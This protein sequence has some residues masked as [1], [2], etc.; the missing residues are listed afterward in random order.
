VAEVVCKQMGLDFGR[1][2]EMSIVPDGDNQIWLD[3]L[4]CLRTETHIEQCN[5]NN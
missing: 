3:N 2:V 1:L 5:H 4:A